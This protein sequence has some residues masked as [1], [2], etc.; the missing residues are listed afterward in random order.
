MVRLI[1]V[2]GYRRND[3][4]RAEKKSVPL[5]VRQVLRAR[6]LMQLEHLGLG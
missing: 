6:T 3:A 1:T 2:V 4:F 5:Q